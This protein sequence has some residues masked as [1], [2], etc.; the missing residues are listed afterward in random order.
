[1]VKALA[2]RLAEAAAEYLHEKVRQDYWGHDKEES[3]SNQ[4]LIE[5]RYSG[6][7]PA[8]GYPACPDHTDKKIIFDLDPCIQDLLDNQFIFL[9]SKKPNHRCSCLLAYQ[10]RSAVFAG[11]N[12]SVPEFRSPSGVGGRQSAQ[13]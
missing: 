10:W 3:Y 4:Q 7:R 1:M 2:D 5:E 8:P 9:V 13:R 11:R 12:L 6:I